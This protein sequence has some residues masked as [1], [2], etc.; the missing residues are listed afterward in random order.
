[1][2]KSNL[3]H[4]IWLCDIKEYRQLLSV[5]RNEYGDLLF[6]VD[7]GLVLEFIHK[8]PLEPPPIERVAI[9]G[10]MQ[11]SKTKLPAERASLLLQNPREHFCGNIRHIQK[12]DD[13]KKSIFE[14]LEEKGI[15]TRGDIVADG[16][17]TRA[18][19][20]SG[21]DSVSDWFTKL[22]EK[23]GLKKQRTRFPEVAKASQE[24][25]K[26]F[27]EKWESTSLEA[28]RGKRKVDCFEYHK[29][30]LAKMGIAGLDHFKA[31]LDNARKL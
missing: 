3:N 30:Q 13:G 5:K 26:A 28:Q 6:E 7:G 4:R 10:R 31:V 22:L 16:S 24:K 11:D 17:A 27:W 12:T 1:M 23:I 14:A 15:A 18:D 9:L 29:P 8:P 25:A 2:E 20:K 19:I 21:F